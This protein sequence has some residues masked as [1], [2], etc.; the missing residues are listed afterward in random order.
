MIATIVGRPMEDATTPSPEVMCVGSTERARR[1]IDAVGLRQMRLGMVT[2]IP[3]TLL[4]E[5]RWADYDVVA[6]V[7][8][9]REYIAD[10][11]A[12]VKALEALG[13][14]V[15]DLSLDLTPLAQEAEKIESRLK[16]MRKE[17]A[18]VQQPLSSDI[19]R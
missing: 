18:S 5:G 2:G 11:T 16:I 15:P 12:A 1:I 3:G 19:Y 8:K 4:N 9:A 14:L 10:A 17:V 13:R 6:I 7:V